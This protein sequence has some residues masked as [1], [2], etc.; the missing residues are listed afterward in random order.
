MGGV[1]KQAGKGGGGGAR[2]TKTALRCKEYPQLRIESYPKDDPGDSSCRA[3]LG[4]ILCGIGCRNQVEE[5]D[6][7]EKEEET[8]I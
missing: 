8:I 7:E 5:E 2:A 1:L 6:V 4:G 3:P